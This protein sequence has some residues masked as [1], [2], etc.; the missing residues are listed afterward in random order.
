MVKV[1]VIP[2]AIIYVLTC[3]IVL[4]AILVDLQHQLVEETVLQ[5]LNLL[6]DVIIIV[7]MAIVGLVAEEMRPLRTF[8]IVLDFVHLL[9]VRPQAENKK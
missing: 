2:D 7:Y 5:I 9:L 8:V 3:V 4:V 6:L 1:V